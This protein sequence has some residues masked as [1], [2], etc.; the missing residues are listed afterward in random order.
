M[1]EPILSTATSVASPNVS[2][3][4]GSSWRF[5]QPAEAPAI[6][7]GSRNDNP[8]GI[9]LWS[10]IAE[11]YRTH[12]R[13][14]LEPGFWAVAVHR[15]GNWRMGVK[16]RLFRIPFTLLYRILH[17]LLDWIWGIDL[18]YTVKLGRR[19]RLWH[20][21]SM[22][23][24]A[25]SIGDDVHI[26]HNTTF[27]LAH[28]SETSRKPVIEDRVDVGVGVCILGA[29]TVGHDAVVGANSVVVRDV[30]PKSTVFGV[31]AR[32]VNLKPEK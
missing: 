15:F 20:H 11:D 16:P 17:C 4:D 7:D 32:P 10:L 25:Q 2:Q 22:F 14:I 28:R 1:P 26:R 13:T 30:L 8:P 19:V 9:G 24:S 5:N 3:S 31:P 27:G 12:D 23:L 18:C 21:G 29:I 6:R